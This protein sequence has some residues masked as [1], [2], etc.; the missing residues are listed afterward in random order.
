M[1]FICPKRK[2]CF[3]VAEKCGVESIRYL[4]LRE[5]EEKNP[6]KIWHPDYIRKYI[7]EYVPHDYTHIAIVRNPYERLVSGYLDKC[8]TGNYYRLDFCKKAIRFHH[9]DRSDKKRLSFEELV[10]Y[11]ITV[12]GRRLDIHFRHQTVILNLYR[13]KI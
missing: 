9:R 5:Q 8:L 11:M 10:N 13:A 4:I 1:Y 12:P 6:E 3:S 7:S 2:V